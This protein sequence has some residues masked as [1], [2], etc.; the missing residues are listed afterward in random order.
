[1]DIEKIGRI[2]TAQSAHTQQKSAA[3]TGVFAAT[4]DAVQDEAARAVESPAASPE[5]GGS[6]R[7]RNTCYY[8]DGLTFPPPDAPPEFLKAWDEILDGMGWEGGLFI[9]DVM[10]ALQYRDYYGPPMSDIDMQQTVQNNIR[11]LGYEGIIRL[12]KQCQQHLL[13]DNIAGGNEPLY[14]DEIR[15]RITASDEILLRLIDSTNPP[16]AP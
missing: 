13:Q 14:I 4:L 1:M 10:T 16:P 9:H 11:L 8:G 3:N 5:P 2:F 6:G 7:S 12:T 15:R